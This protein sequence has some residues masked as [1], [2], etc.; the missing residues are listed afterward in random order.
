MT[1]FYDYQGND[2]LVS[3]NY[4]MNVKAAA[5]RGYSI[6]AP[7][8]TLPAYKLAKEKGFFYVECDVRL[9][10]DGVAVLLHDASIDRTSNGTGDIANLTWSQVQTYDFG[11]WKSAEYAGTRIPSFEQ[12][13]TLC[14]NIGLHPYIEIS[15]WATFTESQVH[16]LVDIVK[17][18]G[19]D[20]KVTW[21]SFSEVY[22]G[23]VKEYDANATLG[24]VVETVDASNISKAQALK[25]PTNKV[26]IDANITNISNAACELCNSA[27]LPLEVWTVD[28]ASTIIN[29]NPYIT[30]FTSNDLIAGKILYNANIS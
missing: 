11:S 26:F 20:N 28:D 17:S 2:F 25:L 12:F 16:E 1:K 6:M 10:S 7:E 15:K 4:D 29:A 8:N 23:Y 22:L 3:N 24:F 30:G 18:R 5:H 13:I 27:N 21:I 9:T 14:R 19:M